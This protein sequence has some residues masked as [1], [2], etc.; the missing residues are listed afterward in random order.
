MAGL[1]SILREIVRT[2]QPKL[3]NQGENR[4]LHVTPV[5]QMIGAGRIIVN[6]CADSV[7][8]GLRVRYCPDWMQGR[9]GDPWYSPGSN[10]Y[11]LY[12]IWVSKLINRIG[13]LVDT[14]VER[15]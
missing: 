3:G 4:H 10:L 9:V 8:L 1:F 15:R 5:E 12:S 11:R 2:A 6:G 13:R 7:I 14:L